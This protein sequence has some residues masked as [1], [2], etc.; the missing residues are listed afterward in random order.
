MAGALQIF[1]GVLARPTQIAHRFLF[2][3][4]RPHLRQQ[5]GAQQLG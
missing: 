5:P 2:R 4:R 3:R 1:T